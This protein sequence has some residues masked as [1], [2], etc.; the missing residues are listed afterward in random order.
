WRNGWIAAG[1]QQAPASGPATDCRREYG[2]GAA[3][4]P[5]AGDAEE[6]GSLSR[7]L[8]IHLAHEDVLMGPRCSVVIPTHNRHAKLAETL[9]GIARQTLPAQ[10]YEII[11][12]DDGSAP[13]V[14]LPNGEGRPEC[15]LVRLE[16]SERSAARNAGGAIAC[17]HLLVFIDDDIL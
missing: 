13:P 15:R 10:E 9:A 14:V 8:R 11:V 4:D 12:V 17:G 3:T 2:E 16:G 6:C 5:D 1:F 7:V